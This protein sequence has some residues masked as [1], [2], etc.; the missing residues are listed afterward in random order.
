MRVLLSLSAA[1]LLVA[2]GG[3]EEVPADAQASAEDAAEAV[4]STEGFIPLELTEDG[5]LIATLPAPGEDGTS[6][7]AIHAMSL[8]AGL[9]SNPLGLDRGLGER[10]RVIRFRVIGERVTAEAENTQ[11]V[12]LTDNDDERRAVEQSFGRSILWSKKAEE[13]TDE[14]V[15]VD[16]SDLVLSDLMDLGEGLGGFSM[17]KDRSMILGEALLGF[18]DNTEIDTEVT[19][20]GSNPGIEV[21]RTAPFSKAVTLS[22]HHTLARLPDAG[23]AMKPADPRFGSFE[24]VVYDFAAPLSEEVP[25]AFALR[26]RVAEDE[27]IV[28]YVDRGAPEPVRS[29]LLEGA[30]WWAEGFEAAG[31]PDAYRVEIL[32]EGIHPADIRYNVIRWV[33]RQTRGWSYGG[34]VTDPRTGEMLKGNVILGSQRV[35]QDRMIFEG[36]AGT[37][38]TGSGDAD[39]PIELSLARIRQLSAHEVGH[40]LGFGHN[41]AASAAGRASV[42][43]YPAPF[44]RAQNGSL[45]F[46]E[47]Y[48]VGLGEWD[49]LTV[50]WL[51]GEED[52]SALAQEARDEGLL[53]IEDSEGRGVGTTHPEAAVWDNGADPVSELANVIAVRSIGIE[54]FGED[55]VAEGQD[56]SRLQQ[57]LVPIYLYHRYQVV[58]AA[59]SLGGARYAYGQVG[60]DPAAVEIVAA[61]RQLTAL[62]LILRTLEPRF[63]SLPEDL[64]A[65]LTP[66]AG[67]MP[68]ATQREAFG[69]DTGAIFDLMSAAEASIDIS[70][71]A[72][73]D[74]ARLE[75]LHQFH[76]RDEAN[77]SVGLVLSTLTT[78]L[79]DA[80]PQTSQEDALASLVEARLVN[81]L[82]QAETNARSAAV[83]AELQSSLR[84]IAETLGSSRDAQAAFLVGSIE[85]HLEAP[86]E[87]RSQAGGDATI[88]PGSPIGEGC[89]H[90]DH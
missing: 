44:I 85:R 30:R 38:N 51:Y 29:A 2:C 55:R 21:R 75:R 62:E 43:D 66:G 68:F 54:N 70:L 31:L 88:P 7:R 58:S 57:V 4:A 22:V 17:D 19:F 53:F 28:F 15:K 72:I 14:F 5:K 11:F 87:P 8:T 50:R 1:A 90:C 40:A 13:V 39:D 3:S 42:M 23:Y 89:F 49:K 67:A 59:K 64:L 26:H 35:R 81:A 83:K 16:I 9:G 47:T 86:A 12:A 56:V 76:A 80:D 37:E 25:R 61:D 69:S 77:P 33:H 84:G 46:S 82:I 60:D 71:G 6:L 79:L 34:A 27:P 36:L 78:R 18:P 73:L 65:S 32:P 48:D 52:S 10:G 74:E 63:L 24:S 45:D 41:F 20:S